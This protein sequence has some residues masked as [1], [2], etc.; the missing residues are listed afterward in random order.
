M[1]HEVESTSCQDG[2]CRTPATEL[3]AWPS[4]WALIAHPENTVYIATETYFDL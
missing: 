3:E 1:S 4:D 2:A